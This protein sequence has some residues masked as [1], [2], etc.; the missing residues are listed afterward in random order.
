MRCVPASEQQKHLLRRIQHPAAAA[1]AAPVVRSGPIGEGSS[2][3]FRLDE[4]ADQ[5]QQC[6]LFGSMALVQEGANLDH[7]DLAP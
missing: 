4:A 5:P 3:G 1:V 2:T 6:L 7:R